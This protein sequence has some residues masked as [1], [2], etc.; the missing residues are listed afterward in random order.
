M[1]KK[2]YEFTEHEILMKELYKNEGQK[3]LTSPMSFLDYQ[4][5]I[6]EYPNYLDLIEF[7]EEYT[8]D[9]YSSVIKE[10]EDIDEGSHV[11]VV[12]HERYSFPIVHK[13]S[14]IEI[15]YVYSGSCQHYIE[16]QYITM[17]KGTVCIL[18]LNAKHTPIV[19]DDN[20]IVIN[21]LVSKKIINDNFL[22]AL[23]E[24]IVLKEF[25]TK[26][27]YNKKNS[28]HIIFK[29]GEDKFITNIVECMYNEVSNKEHAYRIMLETY[30]SQ[31]LIYL[32]RNYETKAILAG[33]ID[34]T[35]GDIIT[36]V[37]IYI[38][39]NYNKVSL[40]ELADFFNYNEAYLSRMIKR[41]TGDTLGNF[42]SKLQ[43]KHSIEL[44]K[45]E[46]MSFAEISQIVGC[47]DQSHFNRKFKSIYGISP[48]E[49]KK[50]LNKENKS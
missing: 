8:K 45:D 26:V 34:G 42:I 44:M 32:V 21:I 41:Y 1:I 46:K 14:Y 3:L 7:Y 11:H 25:L 30:V 24:K 35:E 38:H 50:Q 47:Y 27:L 20:T 31:M 28:S 23:K 16:G 5:L 13:H 2:L 48:K 33:S 39:S 6:K 37:L 12:F 40:K 36:A 43:M 4:K 18:A 19:V 15:V 29:T 49:Y 17:D 10:L 9:I 22:D